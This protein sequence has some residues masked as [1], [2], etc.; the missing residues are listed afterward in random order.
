MP[1][2]RK[3]PATEPGLVYEFK[4]TLLDIKPLIWRSI[5]TP[6]CTLDQLH[7]HIQT[8]LG[9]TNSHLHQFEVDGQRYGD[10]DLLDDGWE[11]DELIDSTKTRLRTI[12]AKRRK[13]FRFFYEY[14]F[15]D[16]W[17][18][19]IVFAARNRLSQDKSKFAA[20]MEP[21]LARPRT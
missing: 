19:E 1:A 2:E 9:W 5:R 3:T 10:P 16:G 20:L 12:L 14:D 13:G 11:D 7:E 18:H 6:D 8:A 17:R 21:V 15:G 4:I